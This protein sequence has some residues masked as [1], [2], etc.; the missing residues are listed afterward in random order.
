MNY[1]PEDPSFEE[2]ILSDSFPNPNLDLNR[3]KWPEIDNDISDS[4]PHTFE[5]DPTEVPATDAKDRIIANQK[6]GEEMTQEEYR[7][8]IEQLNRAHEEEIE[9]LKI[10]YEKKIEEI[11]R[12]AEEKIAETEI[13]TKKRIAILAREKEEAIKK[14]MV[15]SSTGCFNAEYLEKHAK[16]IFNPEFSHTEIAVIILDLNNLKA[17]NDSRGHEIGD[18]L[19]VETAK[20][21]MDN[22]RDDD[23]VFRPYKGDEFVVVC[24]NKRNDDHFLENI[25]KKM[26]GLNEQGKSILQEKYPEHEKYL[27]LEIDFSFG[28][29]IKDPGSNPRT[30]IEQAEELMY[31]HKVQNKKGR[32]D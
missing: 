20:L 24:Y 10:A 4:Q 13:E 1:N 21:L 12:E 19:I 2:P 23:I 32:T 11:H 18:V 5:T 3:D 8:K 28:V 30:A 15:D 17:T 6:S 31:E 26:A 25:N 22:F 16:Q 9:Q 14:G 27:G 7:N 29:T